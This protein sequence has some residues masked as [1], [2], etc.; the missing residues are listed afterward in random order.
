MFW[1]INSQKLFYPPE[2]EG[3]ATT[4]SVSP[5]TSICGTIWSMCFISSKSDEHDPVLAILL[6]RYGHICKGYRIFLYWFSQLQD[7][8]CCASS[9]LS[10]QVYCIIY[11]N[12]FIA[13]HS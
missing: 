13:E 1:L 12:I 8:C 9:H 6:N 11:R 2:N 4:G 7:K 5:K 3:V 10:P